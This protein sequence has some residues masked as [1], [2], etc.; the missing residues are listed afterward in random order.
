MT[1]TRDLLKQG[2]T[3]Q[4]WRKYCGFIDL[5][6]DEFMQVQ[7]E[8]LME[9]LLRLND[10]E[11]GK[12]LIGERMPESVE[13]FRRD[14]SLTSYKDYLP[15]LTDKKEDALYEK[16]YAWVRTS[17][18][19]GE[20]K[21]KWAPYSHRLYTKINFYSLAAF[22]F[23]ASENRYDFRLEAGDKALATLAPPPYFSGMIARG[24]REEFPLS[25]LPPLEQ[26]EKM[27]FQDRIANG[28]K[29]ALK[30]DI[31]IFYG[32]S[33]VLV[34][35]GERFEERSGSMDRSVL[36]HPRALARLLKGVI[37]SKL[38]GRPMLPQ[39]LWNVKAIACGGTDT[40]IYREKIKHYWG[41]YPVEGYASTESG[42]IAMQIWGPSMTFVP[43][44]SFLEFIPEAEH[45][46]SREDPNYK[47][48]VLTL[49]QVKAGEIY[50]I[51]TT[52]FHGGAFVR[53]RQGDLIR[54][55]ALR[56]EEHEI[57]IPQMVFH[58]RADDV[59][60]LGSFVR[61]TETTI[62]WALQNAQIQYTDWTLA[63][64]IRDGHPNIHLY[65]EP[66]EKQAQ[67]SEEVA[68]KLDV[69]LRE[70]DSDY[71]EHK[72]ILDERLPFATLLT[73]GTFQKYIREK[74]ALGAELAHLKPVRMRPSV[75]TLAGLLRLSG[76]E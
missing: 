52:N 27:S 41:K 7:R 60:D 1:T 2:R 28:F 51:V 62:S 24:L 19:S 76:Q 39:D 68:R 48:E 13:E 40:A 26:A 3:D 20:Y 56:D 5:S 31:D 23:A 6:L 33:S 37:K 36:L 8:L 71:R 64:E 45:L 16:P 35:I 55:T 59:I 44:V 54:I 69:A 53:Y 47:P 43:D 65:L 61:L 17:G 49:D 9:Q 4:I 14:V 66:K 10:S 32:L 30:E 29:L 70:L 18:R 34:A 73:P 38:G 57:D 11:L 21:F 72:E 22:I 58:S 75:Q 15:Y 67:T 25:Y 42:I 46:K 63:K 74:Q 12:Q 50:E